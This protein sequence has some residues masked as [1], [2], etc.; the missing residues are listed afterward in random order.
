MAL[1]FHFF[2]NTFRLLRIALAASVVVVLLTACGSEP[3]PRPESIEPAASTAIQPTALAPRSAQA[4]APAAAPI[5]RDQAARP[6]TE[7]TLAPAP[8]PLVIRPSPTRRPAA[9]PAIET[10]ASSDAGQV[11]G[12][13]AP[14]TGDGAAFLVGPDATWGDVYDA[15]S[16]EEQTCIMGTMGEERLDQMTGR[17]F[18]LQDLG[19]ESV[20]LLDCVSDDTA[21]ELFLADMA[22]QSGGLTEEQEGCLRT[23]LGNFSPSEL[24]AASSGEPTPEGAMLMLSFGLGLVGCLPE[25]AAQPPGGPPADTGS[26]DP[27]R[28]VQDPSLLWSFST[29]G[30]V[31][32]APAVAEGVVYIG[33]DDHNL[34]ALTADTGE[35][36]WSFATGDVIRSTPTVVDG[37]VFFG[38][39]DN[40]VY[41][42][43]A[44]TG[45]E[46]WRYD[47][48]GWV[49][50]SPAVGVGRVYFGA[51]SEGDRRVHAID[52]ASGE[53][54]WISAHPFPI[55]AEHTPTPIGDRLYAQ[56]AEY[57]EF[58][59]LDA[60]T[61]ETAWQAEVGGYVESGPVM[62]DGVVY[63]TV[64]NQAYAFNEMTGDVIWEVNT[65]EFLARDFPALVVNGVY[66]LSPSHKV[67]AL[68]ASTGEE[69]W[70]YESG[71]LSTAPVVADGVLYGASE[72]AEYIF[73]LAADTGEELWTTPSE[74]FSSFSLAV[75][76]GILYGQLTEGYVFA[77]DASNG[78]PVWQFQA[79]GFSDIRMYTVVDGVVYS[80][81]PNNG[82]YAHGAP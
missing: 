18:S 47:T 75:A 27:G 66:Y 71:M 23:L 32:T 20:P 62:I 6:V 17:P 31:V 64:I 79:G 77:A 82:V 48:G 42:L 58:Y 41:A 22:A 52:A 26:N 54:A 33:S 30:W 78:E 28:L 37:R 4:P 3:D 25:L 10:A 11:A 9:T 21:R 50:Y 61:G 57:G 39:N 49:Q 16:E 74:D 7:P 53:V 59:A 8:T 19:P 1:L 44:A 60:A 45:E 67:Y 51:S 35:L 56:G 73:A 5:S 14:D 12:A 72:D 24:A 13:T 80:A 34:Y 29:G 81:G 36:L 68:D 55:G 70:S 76:D 46:L 40:H 15:L 65:E 38:S 2:G 43:D 69:I 63:L